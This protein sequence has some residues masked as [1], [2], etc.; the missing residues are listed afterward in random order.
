M[1]EAALGLSRAQV[2]GADPGRIPALL[3]EAHQAA[4]GTDRV[5]LAA[6]LV[7][8]WVYGGQPDRGVRFAH[9]AVAGAE[10]VGDPALLAEALDAELLVHWGPDDYVE[11]VRITS[12]LE[13]TVAHLADVE[14]RQS[15]YLWRLTTAVEALDMPTLRRQLRALHRL[16]EESGSPRAAFFAA[17]RAAMHAT[18]VGDLD[19]AR[20][21]RA[22]AVR[23][24]VEAGEPDTFAIDHAL[25]AAIARP[26]GDVETLTREA[27]IYE[28]FGTFEGVLSVAV[29]A[30]ALWLAA[31]EPDRARS[32]LVQL[33]GHGLA[34]VPRDVD[35]LLIIARATEVAAGTGELDLA[36]E[37]YRLLQP[38]ARRGIPNGGAAAFEGPVDA[39]LS[40]AAAALGHSDD[41]VRW[42]T[43]AVRLAQRFGAT[44][45]IERFAAAGRP[46]P[47]QRVAMLRPG[48]DGVWTVGYAGRTVAVREMKGFR[49]LRL[50]L[51]RPG[52]EMSALEL[53]SWAAGHPDQAVDEPDLGDVVDRRALAAYRQRLAEL[54]IEIAEAEQWADHGRLA[55]LRTERDALLDQVAAATG[56]GGRTR[57]PGGS[58]ERARIA[59][60]K[61]ITA[62]VERIG[63]VDPALA[64]VLHRD[65]HTGA[66]C[67]YDPE[68]SR[69]LT[70]ITDRD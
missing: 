5:R 23:A 22:A 25:A 54:G 11:R 19:G 53:S 40:I 3:F 44:W 69:P 58:A 63:E 45:W 8:T 39:Y 46:D 27:R 61:A 50:L 60:R 37:G 47:G 34:G 38:Y 4:R 62:A 30:A 67:R 33:V 51:G 26:A 17:A 41:A 9:E 28:A 13:D 35:W 18:V 20:S 7:R 31:G 29:E 56:L 43:S 10:A 48:P 2:F 24:G 64:D 70:W 36:A 68:P 15:A 57:T 21:Y 16:A 49:Y 52:R 42:A 6:A 32:L 12:R 65:V 66:R 59:V 55:R 1:T 14:A